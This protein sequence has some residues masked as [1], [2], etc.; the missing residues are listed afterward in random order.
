MLQR[1][2]HSI[3]RVAHTTS[4]APMNEGSQTYCKSTGS[5]DPKG[6]LSQATDSKE[7]L[8]QFFL[9]CVVACAKSIQSDFRSGQYAFQ[10]LEN[11]GHPS[12]DNKK[13]QHCCVGCVGHSR[14]LLCWLCLPL[15]VTLIMADDWLAVLALGRDDDVVSVSASPERGRSRSRSRSYHLIRR[16]PPDE[17]SSDVDEEGP[18]GET[19]LQGIFHEK[20]PPSVSDRY[21]QRQIE[22][23][24]PLIFGHRRACVSQTLMQMVDYFTNG[25]E[26][27]IGATVDPRSR[28]LGRPDMRGHCVSWD[29]MIFIAYTAEGQ[30]IETAAI[31][32]AKIKYGNRC[33]NKA[34]DHRGQARGRNNFI[35]MC[36]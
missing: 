36:C 22:G 21:I 16:P 4:F 9:C 30:R 32:F 5:I 27:Y 1:S 7:S 20:S 2:H 24:L 13:P 3:L 14:S 29:T 28:W 23:G 6:S 15:V 18:L 17:E 31:T 34:D 10:W 19:E 25:E 33:S 11:L 35:Y 26:F 12:R 8:K